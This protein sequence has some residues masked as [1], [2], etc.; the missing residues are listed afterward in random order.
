MSGFHRIGFISLLLGFSSSQLLAIPS[1]QAQSRTYSV[2]LIRTKDAPT[3]AIV[4]GKGIRESYILGCPAL[5]N[6]WSVVYDQGR[7]T[8]KVTTVDSKQYSETQKKYPVVA[9]LPCDGSVQ[10]YLPIGESG[11]LVIKH[12]DGKLYRHYVDDM[13]WMTAIRAKSPVSITPEEL[14]QFAP[15]RGLDFRTVITSVGAVNP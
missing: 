9:V 13:E 8:T 10:G 2:N 15:D 7:K 12:R 1:L 4:Q 3:M 5:Q 14:E 6:L 11:V